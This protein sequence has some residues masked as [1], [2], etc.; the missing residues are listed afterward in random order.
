MRG[1]FDSFMLENVCKII[2]EG[3]LFEECE[4]FVGGIFMKGLKGGMDVFIK[5][6]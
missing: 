3:A 5:D 6:C 2:F 4:Q 1:I